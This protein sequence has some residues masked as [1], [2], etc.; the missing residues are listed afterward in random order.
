MF[1]IYINQI[2]KTEFKPKSGTSAQCFM[3]ENIK[4]NKLK[5]KMKKKL[6]E[7]IKYFSLILKCTSYE[8]KIFKK[9]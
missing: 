8:K 4:N 5:P 3:C 7:K 2:F 9:Q 1:Q 6:D